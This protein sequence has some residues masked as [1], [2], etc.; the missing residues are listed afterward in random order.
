MAHPSQFKFSTVTGFF[1]QDE[2][3]TDPSTI[4]YVSFQRISNEVRFPS[5]LQSQA[6]EN[7]G[8]ITDASSTLDSQWERF[9]HKIQELNNL[10][11]SSVQY[12]VLFLGRHGQGVHNV[13][14]QKYGKAWDV[15]LLLHVDFAN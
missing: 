11:G 14:E 6:K 4:D 5:D 10:G 3:S 12:K 2:P 1:L 13:A 9:K 8:L 7:F 15:S